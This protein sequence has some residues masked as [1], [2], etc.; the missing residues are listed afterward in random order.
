[1][2]PLGVLACL[3]MVC[4]KNPAD[5]QTGTLLIVGGGRKPVK[6]IEEFIRC[7]DGGL[8]VVIPA[9]SSVPEQSG[10]EAVKMFETLGAAQVE[11]IFI[12]SPD[13]ADNPDLV[14]TLERASGI[15]F[16]GGVQTRL[17]NRLRGSRAGRAI[18]D[19]YFRRS[20]SIGGTSAG[21]AVQ[22]QVM[23]TGDGDLNILEKDNVK[24]EHGFGFLKD[25]IIDQHFVIRRRNNRLLSL[26]IERQLTGIGIDEDTAI[27]FTPDQQIT[28][29]GE[30]SVLIYD[31]RKAVFPGSDSNK[32]IAAGLRLSVLH[33]GQRFDL[34]SGKIVE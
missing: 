19:L 34:K 23:I 24:T 28:V 32:L 30:G 17:M 15:F 10:P 13:S 1:M 3:L 20:G 27:I 21:A 18:S 31:P 11:C 12:S 9:A 22:S 14:S 33:D 5:T 26:V 16:T 6:A 25:I 2:F 29:F 4:A 7:C 8:I